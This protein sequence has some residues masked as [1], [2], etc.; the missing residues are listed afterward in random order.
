MDPSAFLSMGLMGAFFIAIPVLFVVL[1]VWSVK[2]NKKRRAQL[3][4]IAASWGWNYAPRDQSLV[5][6]WTVSP[7]GNGSS[8]AA[9]HVLWGPTAGPTGTIRQAITFEYQYTISSGSGDNRSSTTY[10]FHITV[11]L[12][13]VFTP[14][15]ML[16][17]EGFGASLA[18]FFGG[19]DIQFESEDF[20]KAWRIQSKDLRFAHDI[21]H[22]RMM[23][24]LMEPRNRGRAINLVGDGV[25]V[26][27]SGKLMP[28]N[29]LPMV[30]RCNEFLELLPAYV[31]QDRG[32]RG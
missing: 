32:Y 20:N 22:P 3:A 25:M 26:V 5:T 9:N 24:F 30:T 18:K 1:I 13:P 2:A 16:T 7:F 19:Q 17:P 14:V 6:R 8:R 27:Q 11:V 15:L 12:L 29:V 21:V 10:Y 23:E 31:L 28:E 4:A